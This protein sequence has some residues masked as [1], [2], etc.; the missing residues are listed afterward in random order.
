MTPA[1]LARRRTDA[2]PDDDRAF[3][4]GAFAAMCLGMCCWALLLALL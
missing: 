4:K 2:I 3:V 1:P